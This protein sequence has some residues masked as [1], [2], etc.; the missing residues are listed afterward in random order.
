M[1]DQLQSNNAPFNKY[2]VRLQKHILYLLTQSLELFPQY[3]IAQHLCHILRKKGDVKEP[4]FWDD[5]TLLKKVEHYYDE[6]QTELVNQIE[7][8]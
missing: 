3:T 8:D 2:D 5:L 1:N 4:Y 7:E 6:L